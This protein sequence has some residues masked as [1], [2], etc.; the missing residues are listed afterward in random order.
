MPNHNLWL[1]KPEWLNFQKA[2]LQ[3]KKFL[4]KQGVFSMP[5]S[6]F[7]SRKL[8]ERT[9]KIKI[10]YQ[11]VARKCGV[12]PRSAKNYIKRDLQ[13][14][15]IVCQKSRYHH[16]LFNRL[17]DGR[18][19][20][21]LTEEGRKALGKNTSST[22]PGSSPRFQENQQLL[23][24]LSTLLNK[25]KPSLP[26][27]KST[28]FPK[29]WFNDS[30]LLKKTYTLLL[31]KI[32]KGYRIYSPI[33]WISTVLKDKGCGYRQKIAKDVLKT[34]ESQNFNTCP[35][36]PIKQV[37]VQL[38]ALKKRGLDT[39][40]PSLSKLLR[41]GLSHLGSALTA[42]DKLE[43]YNPYVKNLTAFL[44]YLVSLKDLY[45]IF[46]N[47]ENSP[48]K[49]VNFVKKLLKKHQSH[50]HFVSDPQELPSTPETD[51]TYLQ[52]LIHKKSPALSLLKIFQKQKG[53]WKAKILKMAEPCFITQTKT[54]VLTH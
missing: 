23:L 30:S 17:C 6:Q 49:A 26:S 28:P 15:L 54:L 36:D 24:D 19:T 27:D 4:T 16:P 41:K 14:G 32:Q 38:N 42:F 34:L 13:A 5:T 33:K 48:E 2:R 39:S 50:L 40:L 35:S 53:I 21:S 45:S 3:Q 29:W 1:C 11:G 31:K 44:N 25:N 43:K 20:Y 37:Y 51:K 22:P 18:N 8:F 46:S 7:W 10:S 9:E 47:L 12:T 52:F